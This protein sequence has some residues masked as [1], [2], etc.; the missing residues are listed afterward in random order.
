M[1]LLLA[2]CLSVKKLV[3]ELRSKNKET[4]AERLD[5]DSFSFNDF[6]ELWTVCK[7]PRMRKFC[8]SCGQSRAKKPSTS[9]RLTLWPGALSQTS[10]IGSR[11]AL[12]MGF[13]PDRQRTCTVL[14]VQ[15]RLARCIMFSTCPFVRP[16]VCPFVRPFV[17][18]QLVNAVLRKRMNRC[19]SILPSIFARGKVDLEG[20]EVKDKGHKRLKLYLEVWRR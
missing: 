16:S 11:F 1:Y 3:S 9:G 20:Q 2:F 8:P 19:Q 15:S 18:Y 17:C 14:F 12:A 10:V 4:A 6:F 5:Y 13:S 7:I